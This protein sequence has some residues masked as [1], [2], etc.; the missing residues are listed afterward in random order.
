MKCRVA[1]LMY[2]GCSSDILSKLG[3]Q[4]NP[5]LSVLPTD[6]SISL[7]RLEVLAQRRFVSRVP[8]NTPEP[9]VIYYGFT[10]LTAKYA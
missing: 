2:C 9:F 1:V 3:N 4:R 6:R 7:Q 5:N 8:L 10:R